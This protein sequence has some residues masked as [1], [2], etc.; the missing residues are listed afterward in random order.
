MVVSVSAICGLLRMQQISERAKPVFVREWP[1]D[2][3]LVELVVASICLGI[4]CAG[5]FVIATQFLIRG[6]LSAL[7]L[8]EWL[9]AVPLTL[10]VAALISSR[11]ATHISDHAALLSASICGVLQGLASLISIWALIAPNWGSS[12]WSD[13]MGCF[14][15]TLAGSYLAYNILAHPLKI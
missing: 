5:P 2:A 6:R 7:T 1:G 3:T 13:R 15:C 8:G 10:Y 12:Q 14:A 11:A 4:A 9:W